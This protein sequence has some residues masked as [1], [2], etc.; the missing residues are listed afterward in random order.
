MGHSPRSAFQCLSDKDA[1]KVIENMQE[2]EDWTDSIE[3]INNQLNESC[4]SAGILNHF[5]IQ[6]RFTG[7]SR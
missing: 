5:R 3:Q 4:Q 6:G 2:E 1:K 7:A